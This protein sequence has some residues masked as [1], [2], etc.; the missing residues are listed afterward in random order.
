MDSK[1]L[2]VDR[3]VLKRHK[4]KDKWL[5]PTLDLYQCHLVLTFQ[6]ACF[7][8]NC[9]RLRNLKKDRYVYQLIIYSDTRLPNN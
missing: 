2:H 3:F 4:G 9:A 8:R 1:A 6:F 7:T 5:N